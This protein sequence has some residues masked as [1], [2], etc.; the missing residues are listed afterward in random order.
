MIDI[1]FRELLE[2]LHDEME[3]AEQIDKEGWAHLEAVK[4][5]IHNLLDDAG[6]SQEP[7]AVKL[8]NAIDYF[9]VQHPRITEVLS[10]MLASLSAAGI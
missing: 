9:E 1:Q 10:E 7:L 2:S 5:D 8:R 6:I 3:Q 4:L